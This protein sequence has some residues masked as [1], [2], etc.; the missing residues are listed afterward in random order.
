MYLII[1][2]FY[3]IIIVFSIIKENKTCA[4]LFLFVKYACVVVDFNIA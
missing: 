4:A 1:I 2:D 3:L